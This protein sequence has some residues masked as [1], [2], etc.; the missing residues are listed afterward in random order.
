M[1]FPHTNNNLRYHSYVSDEP[2]DYETASIDA[3]R[4]QETRRRQKKALA[5]MRIPKSEQARP[6]PS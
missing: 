4:Y 1:T 3:V 6:V 5:Q 2:H